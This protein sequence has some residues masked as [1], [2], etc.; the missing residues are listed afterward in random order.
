LFL[1][2]RKAMLVNRNGQEV[3]FGRGIFIQW[4][5]S[6]RCIQLFSERVGH[7]ELVYS[8]RGVIDNKT[9][10]LYAPFI[11]S[12]EEFLMFVCLMGNLTGAK[13]VE[14]QGFPYPTYQLT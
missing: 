2:E 8:D 3:H 12:K 11:G 4:S 1:L 7:I 5:E 10:K 6:S 9:E 13:V 14:C